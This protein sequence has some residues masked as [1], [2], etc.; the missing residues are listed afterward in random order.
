MTE[1]YN[2]HICFLAT[3]QFKTKDLTF[4]LCR[5]FSP[6]PIF[7]SGKQ[8]CHI[9]LVAPCFRD[10]FLVKIQ[11]DSKMTVQQTAEVKTSWYRLGAKVP[12]GDD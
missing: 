1:Y 7:Q 10:N 8:H 9:I 3:P 6:L 5:K 4:F 11:F 2:L 12:F